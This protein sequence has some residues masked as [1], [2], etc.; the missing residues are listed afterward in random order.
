MYIRRIYRIRWRQH[1]GGGPGA[2]DWELCSGYIDTPLRNE[3]F[4]GGKS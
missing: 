3:W 2:D 1:I 4:E